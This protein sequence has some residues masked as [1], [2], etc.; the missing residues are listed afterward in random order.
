MVTHGR[1]KMLL[2]RPRKKLTSLQ[3][4][5]LRELNSI[6]PHSAVIES[7]QRIFFRHCISFPSFKVSGTDTFACKNRKYTQKGLPLSWMERDLH[8]LRASCIL[9]Y[10]I[11]L[12][13][14]FC[15]IRA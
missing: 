14:Y 15:R 8:T 12:F 3:K 10:V 5:R 13:I 2:L 6:C 9:Y 11:I 7:V 4:D 1:A